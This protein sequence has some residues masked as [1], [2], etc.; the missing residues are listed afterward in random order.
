LTQL[1]YGV[2]F[3]LMPTKESNERLYQPVKIQIGF[4]VDGK[5]VDTLRKGVE[6][7][8]RMHLEGG[9]KIQDIPEDPEVPRFAPT[10]VDVI[11]M[12][13]QA[14]VEP[15]VQRFNLPPNPNQIMVSKIISGVIGEVKLDIFFNVHNETVDRWDFGVDSQK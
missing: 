8:L 1:G 12:S 15:M 10:H 14:N 7:E 3:H 13:S 9:E 4:Y 6:T 5:E 2:A 11:T